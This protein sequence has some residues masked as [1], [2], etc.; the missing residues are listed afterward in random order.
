M[1]Q[2]ERWQR[3]EHIR[4]SRRTMLRWRWVMVGLGGLLAAALLA[5]GNLV[6]GG[7]LAALLVARVVMLTKMQ[8]LW[9]ARDAA[10]TRRF[11]PGSHGGPGRGPVDAPIDVA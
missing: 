8:R 5:N 1:T 11:G 9:K 6:I 3:V 2:R 10:F 4:S 7:I